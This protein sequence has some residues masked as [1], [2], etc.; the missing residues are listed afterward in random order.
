M[1]KARNLADLL[2][3][4]GDVKSASLDNVPA[5]NNASALTTGTLPIARIADGT[6]TAAKVA[7][8]VATQA[9]LDAAGVGGATG[10]DFN[11][12]VAVRLGT[13]NDLKFIHDGS[14]SYIED[15][16]TGALRILGSS[17]QLRNPADNE[18]M[19]EAYQNGDVKLYY[20]SAKKF[21]TTA[22]GAKISGTTDMT[23]SGQ[24]GGPA[25]SGTTQVDTVAEFSGAGNQRLYVG[26]DTSSNTMWFQNNNPGSLDI[27]YALNLQA[28]GGLLYVSKGN[29]GDLRVGN[30]VA[31]GTGQGV[32]ITSDSNQGTVV[33]ENSL[34]S[35]RSAMLFVNGN[36]QVG[37]IQTNGSSTSYN[38]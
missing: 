28:N 33:I 26:T 15:T 2:D 24:S 7:A 16:G 19:L 11:D 37:T 18:N 3:D 29:A 17:I 22:D 4:N 14:N 25:S 36:G 8:D 34:T 30:F 27:N 32:K 21:E 38:T 10:V 35:Q 23:G 20:D 5:S 12:N 9:E 31:N 1:G 13:G 6:V